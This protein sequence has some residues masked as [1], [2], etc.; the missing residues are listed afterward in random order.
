MNGR[1]G[2]TFGRMGRKTE[3]LK[4]RVLILQNRKS[5]RP[6]KKICYN[7]VRHESIG[8][9]NT[10][11]STVFS[12]YILIDFIDDIYPQVF[13][14]S[15]SSFVNEEFYWNKICVSLP[16]KSLSVLLTGMTSPSLGVK[17]SDF[18]VSEG[19]INS[20]NYIFFQYTVERSNTLIY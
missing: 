1:K 16:C 5:Y 10:M 9:F 2:S 4:K 6:L 17:I 8:D 18:T 3:T 12:I 7:D 15:P 14:L 19:N 13:H 11:I 20:S